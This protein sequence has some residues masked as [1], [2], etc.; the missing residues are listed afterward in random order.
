M[1]MVN[2]PFDPLLLCPFLLSG[3]DG[4]SL[5]DIMNHENDSFTI[6]RAQGVTWEMLLNLMTF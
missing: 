5:A 6:G 3:C 1:K 4:W 2:M